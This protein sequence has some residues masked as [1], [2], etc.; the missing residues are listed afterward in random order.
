MTGWKKTAALFVISSALAGCSTL[1]PPIRQIAVDSNRVFAESADQQTFL[2]LLR[3]K[4]KLPMHFSS[5]RYFRG[6]VQVTGTAGVGSTLTER[7]T[8]VVTNADGSQVVTGT[9]STLSNGVD[10][11][12]PNLGMSV[13]SNPNFEVAYYDS[14]EFQNGILTPVKPSLIE[15]YLSQGWPDPFL[16]ALFISSVDVI[17]KLDDDTQ[18]TFHLENDPS[19]SEGPN[20]GTFIR[21]FEMVHKDNPGKATPLF[22]LDEVDDLNLG[23]LDTLDGSKF[24]IAINPKDE[25]GN[26]YPNCVKD[27]PCLMRVAKTSRGITFKVREQERPA[28]ATR[29]ADGSAAPKTAAD[30]AREQGWV[31]FPGNSLKSRIAGLDADRIDASLLWIR[32]EEFSITD[33]PSGR[34]T[35][36]EEPSCELGLLDGSPVKKIGTLK[37]QVIFRSPQSVMYFLGQYLRETETDNEP[38]RLKE[39]GCTYLIIRANDAYGQ[40]DLLRVRH[41][42]QN[43][44]MPVPGNRTSGGVCN[45]KYHRGSQAMALVQ[46]LINL[47]KSADALP[48]TSAIQIV[49]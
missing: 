44:A 20:F 46:Q 5:F 24:T 33:D 18:Q 34:V 16:S 47:H 37:L 11:F 48:S 45:D 39:G 23:D 32:C 1:Q 30:L 38:Y 35:R 25:A 26:P 43:Y 27:R 31:N 4:D 17:V 42:G 21:F 29:A 13:V 8:Q 15:F 6:N 19:I 14:K 12:T 10:S 40:G 41:N 2:N 28:S 22:G 36:D 9:A 3:A 49:P 7:G